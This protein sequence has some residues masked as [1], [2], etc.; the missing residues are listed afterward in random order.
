MLTA[1]PEHLAMHHRHLAMDL[2]MDYL[3]LD[4]AGATDYLLMF[5]LF[6]AA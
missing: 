5:R 6:A 3:D 2:A 1:S 4:L